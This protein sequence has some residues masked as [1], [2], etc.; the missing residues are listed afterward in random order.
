MT[1]KPTYDE[2]LKSAKT[3]SSME[4]TLRNELEKRK[5]LENFITGLSA[6]FVNVLP[7]EVDKEIEYAL[8]RI[9]KALDIDRCDFV[10]NSIITH[11]WALEGFETIKEINAAD[12]FPW[13]TKTAPLGDVITF[14]KHKELPDLAKRD[15]E[16]LLQLGIRSGVIVPYLVDSSLVCIIA[17]GSHHSD[18]HWPEDVVQ[19]LKLVSEVI[20]NALHR[21]QADLRLQKAFSEVKRLKD[22]L[23][24]ENT[25]LIEEIK[26]FQKHAEFV[27]ESPAIKEVFEKMEQVA[28]TDSTVL[29]LGET[30]T[31]KELVARAIHSLSLCKNRA[32]VTVNCAALPANLIEGELFGREKGAYTGAISK[33]IGRFETADGSTIFLDEIGEMPMELQVKLLRVLQEGKFERLGSSNTISVNTR[34]ITATNRNLIKE[35]NDGNF[36]EDLYYRLNVFPILIPPLR[37]RQDDILPLTWAFIKE[38]SETMGKRIEALSKRSITAMQ[39]YRWPGNI[40]E[41]RNVVE[42]SMITCKSKKLVVEIPERP[43][44]GP[45][46]DLPLEAY[47]RKYIINILEKTRWRIRGKDGAADLLG[48]KP[49][50][51]HSKMKKLGIQRPE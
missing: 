3:F 32:M 31:G 37:D 46:I 50:T 4:K 27:G 6:K 12:S 25:Y 43:S 22:Q 30:G 45:Q 26:T 9:A 13:L 44:S 28:E 11:S 17:F 35:V 42:R 21:K 29:I 41:L 18:K 7:S 14:S 39:N 51:L 34:I 1:K 40:R 36:R 10:E 49:T 47:E 38:F 20:V 2:L 19:R 8:Q 48:L 24:Q 16:S 5:K 33:Q 23:Q 15:K